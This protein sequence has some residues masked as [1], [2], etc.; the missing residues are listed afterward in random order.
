[1]FAL[2]KE[3]LCNKQYSNLNVVCHFTMNM[4]IKNPR[5]LDKE[6]CKYAMNSA[7]QLDFLIYNKIEKT[8]VGS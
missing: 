6:K 8:V 7:T 5:L 4:L 1:M 3:I 2:I